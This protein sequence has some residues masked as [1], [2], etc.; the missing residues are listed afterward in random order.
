MSSFLPLLRRQVLQR[1]VFS[2]L[3]PTRSSVPSYATQ[4][5]LQPRCIS[6]SPPLQAHHS[7][8]SPQ[9]QHFRKP[10]KVDDLDM[11]RLAEKVMLVFTRRRNRVKRRVEFASA[12]S[13]DA[14]GYWQ[15]VQRLDSDTE[16]TDDK[17]TFELMMLQFLE[18]RATRRT[19]G[20]TQVWYH[21]FPVN[22]QM[23][24]VNRLPSHIK[25]LGASRY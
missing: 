7:R 25:I 15:T 21:K 17:M 11:T 3:V 16:A 20:R 2:F 5:W 9:R 6:T 23:D 1:P 19:T 10:D 8:N 13:R 12:Q 24:P 18:Y 22:E 4:R 14:P